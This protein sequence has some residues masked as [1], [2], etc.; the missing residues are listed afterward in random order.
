MQN[1]RKEK[2][3]HLDIVQKIVRDA[4]QLNAAI[5][6][7]ATVEDKWGYIYINCEDD[8]CIS[9]EWLDKKQSNTGKLKI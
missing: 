7:K 4:H 8:R 9:A 1:T 3:R 6:N 5:Q 2:N